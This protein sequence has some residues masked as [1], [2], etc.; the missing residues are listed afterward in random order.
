MTPAIFPMPFKAPLLLIL[1]ALTAV[2]HASVPQKQPLGNYANLWTNSPFTAKPP[3]VGAGPVA[4][5]LENYALLGVSPI[6]NNSYRVTLINKK[7]ADQR[8]T[9]ETDKPS[10]E[11]LSIIKVNREAGQPLK[12]TVE[13][14]SGAMQGIVSFDEKLLTI[15]APAPTAPP[16]QAPGQMPP[17]LQGQLGAPGQVIQK[18][19]RPRIIPPPAPGN[20][21]FNPAAGQIQGQPNQSRSFIRR[22]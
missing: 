1:P 20:P 5:P 10:A 14:S 7:Q 2:L 6:G 13:M 11:G 17:Q 16:G 9:V 8:I 21:N 4:N 18:Q 19:P 3:V 15:A 22:R 12:T